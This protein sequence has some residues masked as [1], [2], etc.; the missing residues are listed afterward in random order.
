[1]DSTRPDLLGVLEAATV[2]SVHPETVRRAIRAGKL[3]A[4]RI[5]RIFVIRP[6]DLL[7]WQ[8]HYEKAPGRL[9][10]RSK[11]E[12]RPT[13]NLFLSLTPLL[14]REREL[15]TVCA[16]LTSGGKRLVTLTGPGGSGK[17]RLALEVA[18][19]LVD[20]FGHGAWFVDLAPV[21][22][23]ALILP[24]IAQTLGVRNPGPRLLRDVLIDWLRQRR[25]LLVLDNCEHLLA[26]V[27][28]AATL[29]GACPELTVLATSRAMLQ[30]PGEQVV[31]LQPLRLPDLARASSTE[32]VRQSPAVALFVRRAA[33]VD[34]NF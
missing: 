33:A 15:Q 31:P 9:R 29:L 20:A 7:A 22:D 32:A 16:Y 13:H 8:P 21:R 18:G 5:G 17:T 19:Q 4:L 25:L 10:L 6:D 2:K 26:G 1:M 28:E 34:P 27:P 23:P 14:G 12:T 11:A 30:L 3:P 24:T